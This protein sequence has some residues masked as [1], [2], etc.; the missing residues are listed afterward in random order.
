[1]CGMMKI[2]PIFSKLHFLGNSSGSYILTQFYCDRTL[3]RNLA[4]TQG[5]EGIMKII[6]SP[7]NKCKSFLFNTFMDLNDFTWKWFG[8]SDAI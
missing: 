8:S 3:Q 4:R 7:R 6:V 2:T 1:M 5:A